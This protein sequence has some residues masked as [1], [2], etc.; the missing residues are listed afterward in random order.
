MNTL[1]ISGSPDDGRGR[2]VITQKGEINIIISGSANLFTYIK[3]LP[4]KQY[5]FCLSGLPKPQTFAFDYYP[6]IIVNEISDPDSHRNALNKACIFC[7]KQQRPVINHPAAVMNTTRDKIYQN[8]NHLEQ[9][10]LPKTVRFNPKTP[11]DVKLAIKK[12]GFDYPVIFRQAGDHGGI[13]TSKIDSEEDVEKIMYQYAL[14]GCAYYLTQFVNYANK[15]GLYAKT[16]LVVVGDDVFLR[17]HIIAENWLIHTQSSDSMYETKNLHQ[18]NI[19][20]QENFE[21]QIKPKIIET[22]LKIK[23]IIGLDYFGMDVSL[24]DNGQMLVFE[25]NPNMNIL[26][27]RNPKRHAKLLGKITQAITQ[28]II[29]KSQQDIDNIV[30]TKN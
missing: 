28:L 2:L 14:T 17:H 21:S 25:I 10:I 4:G 8:L 9:L 12:E 27:S 19:D 1:F 16:R 30:N 29:Q 15:E 23:K 3:Q 7:E 20:M 18:Q 11:E 6:D 24:K 26:V 5:Q 22:V 13:S